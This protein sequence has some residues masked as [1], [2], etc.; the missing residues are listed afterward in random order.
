MSAERDPCPPDDEPLPN[1]DAHRLRSLLKR[2][3]SGVDPE[4]KSELLERYYPIVHRIVHR[5]LDRQL[6]HRRPWLW[7][8]FSTGDVVQDVFLAVAR[9][10][11]DF[12]GENEGAIIKYLATAVRTRLVDAV[13]FH[14]AGRRDVRRVRHVD[15]DGAQAIASPDPT[16]S[17]AAAL[18]EQV[19]AF[20]A[21]LVGLAERDRELIKLR[22]EDSVPFAAIG[23]RLGFPSADA[24]RKAFVA[25][26]ARLLVKLRLSGFGEGCGE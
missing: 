10:L 9:E 3:R 1:D 26:Q 22:F 20:E 7:A 8:M 12:R 14:E 21:A 13:R 4:A 23:E 16:P 5:E 17:T 19:A 11:D 2:A 24:A 18:A 6:R 15:G 25:A